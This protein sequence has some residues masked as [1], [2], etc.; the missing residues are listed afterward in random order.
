LLNSFTF[1]IEKIKGN[2]FENADPKKENIYVYRQYINDNNL[3]IIHLIFGDEN[4]EEIKK[5]F[6]KLTIQ[7]IRDSIIAT[8]SIKFNL[9]ES[10][11]DFI[12]NNSN[13]FLETGKFKKDELISKIE[14]KNSGIYLK[15]KNREI[16]LKG[17]SIDEKGFCNFHTDMPEP[18]YYY[19]IIEYKNKKYLEIN[20]E[21]F[22]EI[23][24]NDIL[25]E[26]IEE[27]FEIMISGKSKSLKNE[28]ELELVKGNLKYA[29]F[30]I[31]IK[32]PNNIEDKIFINDI[33]DEN[34]E[35]R[36]QNFNTGKLSL[37]FEIKEQ[38]NQ[39]GGR[40][41]NINKKNKKKEIINNN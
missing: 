29:D 33:N 21:C 6:N 30:N 3:E 31:K 12:I 25:I 18:N 28:S 23:E 38:I 32:L 34:K 19:R 27:D 35:L 41:R 26:P 14:E 7:Y 9:I 2:I 16:K 24:I 20:I 36:K 15:N 1:K 5:Y 39:T 22:G 11:K 17:V 40:K 10:F 8:N 4:N 37:Y 13:K